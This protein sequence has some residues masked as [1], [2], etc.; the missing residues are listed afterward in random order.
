MDRAMEK[1]IASVCLLST[2]GQ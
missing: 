2:R 1:V